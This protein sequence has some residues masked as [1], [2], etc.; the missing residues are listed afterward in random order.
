MTQLQAI[1]TIIAAVAGLLGIITLLFRPL[2]SKVRASLST[3]E[4]F[5]RDWNGEELAP[6]RDPAA[7]VMQ[8]LNKIDGEFKRNGGSTMKDD[9]AGMK[10]DVAGMKES[11]NDIKEG[12]GRIEL[13]LTTLTAA[14]AIIEVRVA[15]LE[16]LLR[17]RA[18]EK[19]LNK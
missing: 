1:A 13:S 4:G 19:P 5:M 6:G 11:I 14:E 15:A 17:K 18:A 8:R 16:P 3:W 7:G 9:V 12:M 2:I 10:D